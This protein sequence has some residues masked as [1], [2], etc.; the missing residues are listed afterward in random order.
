MFCWI[1]IL[2][3]VENLSGEEKLYWNR[4]EGFEEIKYVLF[5]IFILIREGGR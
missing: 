4:G 2:F 5:I 3:W 1:D